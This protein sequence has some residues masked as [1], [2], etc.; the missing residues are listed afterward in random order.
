MR[1]NMSAYDPKQTSSRIL[2][3][4]F[5]TSAGG[6]KIFRAVLAWGP[7]KAYCCG[8]GTPPPGDDGKDYRAN[9]VHAPFSEHLSSTNHASRLPA[10]FQLRKSRVT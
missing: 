6:I 4:D 10:A 7:T 8:T 2:I 3:C 5:S 1:A 9:F